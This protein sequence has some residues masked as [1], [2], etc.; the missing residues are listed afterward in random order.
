[1]SRD[2]G[3]DSDHVAVIHGSPERAGALG[4]MLRQGG[5]QVTTV[6]PVSSAGAALAAVGPG[7]VVASPTSVE[8]PPTVETIVAEARQ[9]LTRELPYLAVIGREDDMPP[10]GADDVIREP[11]DGRELLLRARRI[12]RGGV[13]RKLLQR[14]LDELQ[15]LSRVAWAFSLAGGAPGLFGFLSRH[16][17]EV[18]RADKGL[19]LLYDARRHEM[20]AQPPGHGLAPAQVEALRYPVDE[21]R[22]RWHFGT[23]GPLVI[24][25]ARQDPRL[26]P[27]IAE[28][29]GL[30]SLLAVPLTHGSQVAGV[31][32]VADRPGGAPF[33][34]EDVV[35]LQALAGQAS[36][37]VENYRLHQELLAA[38]VQLQEVDR[39]KNEFV[40][41]VA[42]DFRSPLMAIRGYAEL[43][44]ED[45]D[46]GADSRREFMRTIIAQTGD[47]ARLATDT[48]L[49]T[50]MEAGHFD[51]RW[52][53]VELG[54]FI[55]DAVTRTQ[56]DHPLV[57][58]V[59]A[60]MPRLVTDPER[61]RQLLANLISNAVK[62]SPSGEAVTVRSREQ[63]PGQVLIQVI[64]HGLGIPADQMGRLFNKFERV[65]TAA[66]EHI[67]GTGLGLY[68][69]RLIVEAHHGR[70]WAD[71]EPGKG[72]TFSLLLPLAGAPP[73]PGADTSGNDAA[74]AEEAP[75]D[76]SASSA[77]RGSRSVG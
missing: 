75:G 23:N 50:Q 42:H 41:M 48:F 59:P 53:E 64:D 27:G 49:I 26:V 31:L 1:V 17:A 29:L 46:I 57:L 40:A 55:L 67:S 66:H 20:A 34:D 52:Q 4:R 61:L 5:I 37:A 14:K 11:V 16:A 13:E 30:R 24:A 32:A 70:I 9:L 62:Y 19:V 44:L 22:R 73:A 60:G 47:L 3:P 12:L 18:L 58:D 36:V 39:L 35:F 56:T 7:L 51:H 71:S 2:P 76:G 8:G 10:A 43:V 74:V 54:P 21:A 6:S 63:A 65:R 38:N 15:G 68:I 72:S 45:S 28:G 33:R 25:D 69:C 77:V